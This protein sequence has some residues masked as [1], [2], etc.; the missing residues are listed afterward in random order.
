[1][2]G[3]LV[4]LIIITDCH[5]MSHN[6]RHNSSQVYGARGQ[7]QTGTMPKKLSCKPGFNVSICDTAEYVITRKGI[8]RAMKPNILLM[9]QRLGIQQHKMIANIPQSMAP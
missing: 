7:I 5:N 4:S 3:L 1:L 8:C 2:K 9:A 6:T